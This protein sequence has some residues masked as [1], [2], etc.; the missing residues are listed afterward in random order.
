MAWTSP[1]TRAT[2]DLV[3]ASIWNADLVD[4]LLYLYSGLP[5]TRVYHNTTQAYTAAAR[6]AQS[7]NTER[8]DSDTM[9]DTSTN[10]SRITIKTAGKYIVVGHQAWAASPGSASTIMT[11]IELNATTDITSGPLSPTAT[12]NYASFVMTVYNLAVNDYVENDNQTNSSIN[13]MASAGYGPEFA[14]HRI[15]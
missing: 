7:F 4:N 11:W 13:S 15:G 5:S 3:T 1:T 10:N 8:W 14:A 9:H 12:S 6:A 2:D